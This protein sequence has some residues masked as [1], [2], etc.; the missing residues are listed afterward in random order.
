M[1]VSV[2]PPKTLFFS[3]LMGG[4]AAEAAVALA[5]DSVYG[6]A[7]AVWT[8]DL[9]KAHR[10]VGALEAGVVWV[11]CFGDGDMTQPFGGYKQS[12]IGRETHKM[13]LDHYQQTKNLLV[14]YDPKPMGFF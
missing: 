3:V 2:R 9:N 8:A 13:M 7:A 12:G 11:N 14:S 10:M 5:N 4:S 6:L 1:A